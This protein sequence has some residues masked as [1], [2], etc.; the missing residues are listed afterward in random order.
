MKKLILLLAVFAFVFTSCENDDDN[1]PQDPIV[2]AWKLQA[3]FV[4]GVEQEFYGCENEETEV[5]LEDGNFTKYIYSDETVD[6]PGVCVIENTETGTW[7]VS[8]SLYTKII[9]GQVQIIDLT[10][11]GNTY[12]FEESEVI[13]GVTETIKYVFIKQ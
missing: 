13:D 1:S 7:S 2:G 12:F 3:S 5:F 4:N 11:E 8:G 6:N 10:F 9:N